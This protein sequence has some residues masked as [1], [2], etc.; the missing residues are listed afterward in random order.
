MFA[1]S[2]EATSSAL[3]ASEWLLLLFGIL[4][5]IGIVGEYAKSEKWRKHLRLWE[6]LVTVGVAGELLC[7]GGVFLFSKRLQTLEGADI[8][9]LSKTAGKALTDATD[10]E[11]KLAELEPKAAKAL[12]DATGAL[13]KSASAEKESSNALK[14]ARDARSEADTFEERIVS[15]TD[16][17]T[18]AESHLAEA[19]ERASRAEAQASTAAGKVADRTLSPLQ[20]SNIV[21]RLRQFG[22]RRIDMIIIGDTGEIGNIATLIASAIQQAGWTVHFVGKAISGPNV[23]GVLVGT[24]IGSD[25][26]VEAAADALISALRSEGIVSGRFTPQFND[27]LPMAIMGSWDEKNVAP[28]RMLVSAKP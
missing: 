13:V 22:P 1:L 12:V 17:A 25:Q 21:S 24:H 3:D 28:I 15:A 2:K 16:T 8:Q 5:V 18:K 10:A 11:A 19:L 23:S 9:A 20:Q 27:S 4:L 26:G 7:D 14:V 6:I